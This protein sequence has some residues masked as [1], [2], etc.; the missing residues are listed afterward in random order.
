MTALALIA[1]LLVVRDVSGV[2][3]TTSP[4]S[5]GA[6]AL[7]RALNRRW[8]SYTHEYAEW[9]ETPMTFG[10]WPGNE[11]DSELLAQLAEIRN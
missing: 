3:I 7:M 11:T 10:N 9:L 6:E 1:A 4:T 5:K 8:P 2:D